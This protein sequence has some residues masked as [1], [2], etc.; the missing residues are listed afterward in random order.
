MN[1]HLSIKTLLTPE[2]RY[3]VMNCFR[4]PGI[5]SSKRPNE[6][7]DR[8]AFWFFDNESGPRINI[9]NP[10]RTRFQPNRWAKMRARKQKWAQ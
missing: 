10:G 5:G 1:G 8:D 4:V 2:F 9:W 3:H 7:H 6:F